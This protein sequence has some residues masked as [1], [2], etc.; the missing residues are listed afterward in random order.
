MIG[1][2][3]NTHTENEDVSKKVDEFEKEAKRK[4]IDEPY[5][6]KVLIVVDKLLTGFDA[7]PCTYLYI[8]KSMHDHGLFQA[9]CRVNRLDEDKD[10]GY[11]VDYKQLFGDLSDAMNTYTSENP[12]AGFDEEDV[13]GLLKNRKDETEKY[14]NSIL[15]ALEELSDGVKE[16]KNQIDYEHYFCGDNVIDVDNDEVYARIRQKLYGLVNK[17]IRAFSELKPYMDELNYTTEKQEKINKK[18][19]FYTELK[20]IIGRA[21]GDYIDLKSYEPEM[22]YLID[23]YIIAQTSQNLGLFDD[24]TLL[25]FIN[26]QKSRLESNDLESRENISAAESI[27]NNIAKEA[28]EKKVI[29]PKYYEKMSALLAQLI[30]DR[31]NGVLKYKE[32]LEKYV[33]LAEKIKNPENSG[34]YPDS[35]KVRAALRALYDNFGEDEK[36]AL[37]IDSAVLKSRMDGFRNNAVRERQIKRELYKVLNDE[38]KVEE[39]FKIVVAQEEY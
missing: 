19:V 22:R 20:A 1:I 39:V 27:E 32:L 14:F 34:H 3:P 37:A 10:Y 18:V 2:D 15:D 7:H 29:N 8:D 38:N 30:D 26:S 11:I 16:P 25:D 6:M 9:V 4:F 33:E 31:K 21:S 13:E 17:L 23:T 24:Y 35:I 5:N 12:F 36:L 28:V